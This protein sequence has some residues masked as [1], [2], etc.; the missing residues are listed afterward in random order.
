MS[1]IV[2][3][4]SLI[5]LLADADLDG[6]TDT[7]SEQSAI[8]DNTT[9]GKFWDDF[10][11]FA[12]ID[13]SGTVTGDFIIHLFWDNDPSTKGGSGDNI[14]GASDSQTSFTTGNLADSIE[15]MRGLPITTV[16]KR[17]RPV[18]LRDVIGFALPEFGVIFQNES[19]VT[20][21]SGAGKYIKMLPVRYAEG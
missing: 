16:M 19:G 1:Q 14:D 4:G 8:Y 10:I 21:A 18:A 3:Y 2:E 12:A 17:F 7:S 11:F 9:S 13:V 20:V 5:T 6:I 15:I